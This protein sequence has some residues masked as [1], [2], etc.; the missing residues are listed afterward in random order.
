MPSPATSSIEANIH[1]YDQPSTF[2]T[3]PLGLA[4]WT[5][6]GLYHLCAVVGVYLL[7]SCKLY[8]VIFSKYVPATFCFTDDD[9]SCFALLRHGIFSPFFKVFLMQQRYVSTGVSEILFLKILSLIDYYKTQRFMKF[10]L[11]HAA[12]YLSVFWSMF[13]LLLLQLARLRW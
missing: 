5:R 3:A 13:Q 2:K 7:P 4:V 6:F 11:G 10:R 9:F 8:T 1:H 12:R